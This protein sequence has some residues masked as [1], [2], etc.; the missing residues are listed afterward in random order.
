MQPLTSLISWSTRPLSCPPG[1]SVTPHPLQGFG[2]P[3]TPRTVQEKI[4]DAAKV[5][6][7]TGLARRSRCTFRGTRSR[8]IALS[9]NMRVILVWRLARSTPT[10]SKTT[11]TSSAGDHIDEAV[12]RK[13]VDHH[14]ECIE[15]MNRTGSQDLKVWLANG[16][17]YA[18]QGDL[19]G[20]Q[21]RL[22]DSLAQIYERIG[23][24]QLRC[25]STSSSNPPFTT[26]MCPTGVPHTPRSPHW[27][28]GPR[29]VWTR[30]TTRPAP[31]LSSSS[32]SFCGSGTRAFDF[33]SRYYADDD[34]IVGSADPFQ[35]FRILYEVVR[36]GGTVRTP[37]SPSCWIVSQH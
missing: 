31:T 21:D 25:W 34:L 5:N 28:T 9:G 19:R 36:G 27:G 32:L 29:C 37:R 33:N 1:H 30:D 6:E 10:R 26:R 23:P 17:N 4:A 22:A 20:R 3:G 13:A 12:R 2:S 7:L 18:G 14:F 16:T 11:C 35:L 8:T 15:I 24:E